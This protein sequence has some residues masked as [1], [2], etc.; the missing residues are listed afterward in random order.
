[1][2][3]GDLCTFIARVTDSM[4]LVATMDNGPEIREYQRHAKK[5]LKTLKQSSPSR[6][7]FNAG[8]F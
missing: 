7:T 1:M 3:S 2:I 6:C 8:A 4:L 5:L